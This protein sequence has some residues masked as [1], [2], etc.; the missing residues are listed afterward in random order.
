MVAT[1]QTTRRAAPLA[2]TAQHAPSCECGLDLKQDHADQSHRRRPPGLRR[3][4]QVQVTAY[5]HRRGRGAAVGQ[6]RAR[7]GQLNRT[8]AGQSSVHR[9]ADTANGQRR[10]GRAARNRGG[11]TGAAF[12]GCV[13]AGIRT[14]RL[15]PG[16]RQSVETDRA[17][18][19]QERGLER[20]GQNG[21]PMPRHVHPGCSPLVAR[22]SRVRL[23]LAAT[24]LPGPI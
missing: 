2:R 22:P 3:G 24:R 19:P 18:G 13:A 20:Y 17:A 4:G 23:I 21:E 12:I 10:P 15:Q 7:V 8:L 11:F 6:R 14:V 16:Q 9:P 5:R 1:Q